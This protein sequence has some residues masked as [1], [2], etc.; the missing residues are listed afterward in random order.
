MNPFKDSLYVSEDLSD[1]IIE[2]DNEHIQHNFWGS[3][4]NTCASMINNGVDLSDKQLRIVNQEYQ[5]VKEK[6]IDEFLQKI[7]DE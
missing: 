6:R 4:W 2:K 5:K 3:F 7:M 1:F